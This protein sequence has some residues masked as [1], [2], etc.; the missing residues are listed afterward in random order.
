MS[1]YAETIDKNFVK[2]C[3]SVC[4]QIRREADNGLKRILDG[5]YLTWI[6][7]HLISYTYIYIY[8]ID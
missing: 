3:I 5:K 8:T 7:F 1:T 4:I 6:D 2:M